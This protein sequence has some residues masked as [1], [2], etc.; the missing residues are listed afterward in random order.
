MWVASKVSVADF[1]ESLSLNVKEVACAIRGHW[2]VESCHW[3]LDVTFGEDDD[4]T[5][6]VFVAFNFNILRKL[7]L[8]FLRLIDVGRKGVSLR[9][10]RYIISFNLTKYI[11]QLLAA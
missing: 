6:D 5:L 1:H 2:M 10:K 8:N 4:H 7:A 11:Q 3:H 9:K